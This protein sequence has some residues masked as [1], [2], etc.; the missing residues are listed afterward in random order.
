MEREREGKSPHTDARVWP[1][2]INLYA[3]TASGESNNDT[4]IPLFGD[5]AGGGAGGDTSAV[6]NRFRPRGQSCQE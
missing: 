4:L 3:D 1:L 6:E 5:G 2:S